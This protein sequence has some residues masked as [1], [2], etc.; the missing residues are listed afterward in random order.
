VVLVKR[1]DLF[2]ASELNHS[3]GSS[4]LVRRLLAGGT[5]FLGPE[6]E[7]SVVQLILFHLAAHPPTPVP[8]VDF[9]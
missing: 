8:A 1:E 2:G 5:V 9:G 3:Q 4:T 7:Q 6:T